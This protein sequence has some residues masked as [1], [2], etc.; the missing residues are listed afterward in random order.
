MPFYGSCPCAHLTALNLWHSF[1][2]LCGRPH[3]PSCPG[4]DLSPGN[5]VG[6]EMPLS[7]T[8]TLVIAMN[9][10]PILGNLFLFRPMV[11]ARSTVLCTSSL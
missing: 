9:Q 11:W 6:T 3:V 8:L 1:F 10:S 5:A 7:A 2:V 4:K